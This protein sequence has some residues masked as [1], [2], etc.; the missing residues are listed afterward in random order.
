M[1]ITQNVCLKQIDVF[2]FILI[3][4]FVYDISRLV[5]FQMITLYGSSTIFDYFQFIDYYWFRF[6]DTFV[7]ISGFF[8]CIT[9]LVFIRCLV[10]SV[11]VFDSHLLF[12]SSLKKREY[13]Y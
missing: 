11:V 6:V 2:L 7:Y 8:L 10:F 4:P 9:R 13:I 3:P 1:V 12:Q 5:R